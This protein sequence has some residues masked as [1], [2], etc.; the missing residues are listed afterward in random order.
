MLSGGG[1]MW[2]TKAEQL[3]ALLMSTLASALLIFVSPMLEGLGTWGKLIAL[4]VAVPGFAGLY[5]GLSAYLARRR[6]RHIL[7]KWLYL[8]WAD[9]GRTQLRYGLMHF[10]LSDGRVLDYKVKL[11]DTSAQL[12]AASKENKSANKMIGDANSRALRWDEQN[13]R[14]F[15]LWE[16]DFADKDE[17]KRY[18]RL[19]LRISNRERL[20]GDWLSD[21]KKE[22]VSRGQMIAQRPKQ[23]E[24]SHD[25]IIEEHIRS[26]VFVRSGDKILSVKA[27][28]AEARMAASAPPA[29]R[30]AAPPPEPPSPMV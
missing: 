21:P 20:D 28:A 3:A 23:F 24:D 14:I 18:G 25:E 29:A 13:E 19:I 10:Y 11:Y 15:I 1:S 12:L 7:G 9:E 22:G 17:P 27:V 26:G 16:A 4:V 5:F 30:A 2:K 8:T 6:L